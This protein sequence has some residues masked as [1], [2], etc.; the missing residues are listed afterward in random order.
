M[1]FRRR[2]LLLTL[3]I[4]GLALAG[5]QR[6]PSATDLL[7]GLIDAPPG[8]RAPAAGIVVMKDNLVIAQAAVGEAVVG[9]R[10]FTTRTPFRAASI[11]K[12]V[13]ALT[14]EKL[15]N[16]GVIDLDDGIREWLPTFPTSGPAGDA[17]PSFRALLSHTSGLSDPAEYWVAHPGA[18]DAIFNRSIFR[19]DTAFE[20]CNLGYGVVATALEVATQR[21]FD[22]L[23]ADYVL[24]PM[25]L[26]S[27]FNWAGVTL[28]KRRSGASLYRETGRGWEVQTDDRSTLQG[29]KPALLM[30]YDGDLA[31]YQPGQNGTLF[32]PQG[33]LR[34]SLVDLATLAA[35]LKYAPGLAQPVWTLNES[36]TNGVHDQRYYTQFGT[37]V[38]VHPAAESLWP[39]ENLWGHHGEAYGLYAGA[40]YAPGLDLSFAYAVTGTPETPPARSARHPALDAFTEVLMD[41]VMAAYAASPASK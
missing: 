34:A 5:C 35:R 22:R 37:G 8:A 30:D 16:D 6:A 13:T 27:G 40:W 7:T 9:E 21:R 26:D 15:H 20:Y 41:A 10:A 36:Q 14:A 1:R 17:G 19:A 2:D 25:G 31:T 38:H 23:A 33:G 32:S 39:G 29:T 3:P 11:S 4:G 12:L 28:E 24:K 18:I